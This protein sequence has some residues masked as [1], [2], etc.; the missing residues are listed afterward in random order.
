[1]PLS[2]PMPHGLAAVLMPEGPDM[3]HE[4][5]LGL[6]FADPH[7][8]I[9]L[10][11]AADQITAHPDCD[12][13]TAALILAKAVEAGF[14]RGQTPPGYD[15][16]AACALTLRLAETITKGGYVSCRLALPFDA[17]QLVTRQLGPQGVL[18]LPPL[19]FGQMPHRP[20]F[21]FA[22]WRPQR[23]PPLRRVA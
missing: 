10:L 19:S 7:A 20:R 9:D 5:A 3:W 23:H 15:E 16:A 17:V 8:T 18:P 13:S 2:V 22:G 12:R 21:A 4:F 1:M 6:D 14:D 11:I